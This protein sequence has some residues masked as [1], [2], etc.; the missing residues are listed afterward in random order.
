MNP[1]PW[2]STTDIAIEQPY[3]FVLIFSMGLGLAGMMAGTKMGSSKL[4]KSLSSKSEKLEKE[5]LGTLWPDW[6]FCRSMPRTS[7][8]TPAN[9]SIINF[10]K[11]F[12][13]T[14]WFL[15]YELKKCG[16]NIWKNYSEVSNK[17]GVFLIL[18]EKNFQTTCLIRTSMFIHF[19]W[20]I[21]SPR[22]LEPPRLFILGEIPNYKIILSS[23]KHFK[24]KQVSN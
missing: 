14:R 17:Y 20:K 9:F 15:Q 18:F 1:Q 3:L 24:V 2:N 4:A 6:D 8:S 5:L 10:P 21:P 22:L 16:T 7:G 12:I 19:W 13:Q 11:L 23:F